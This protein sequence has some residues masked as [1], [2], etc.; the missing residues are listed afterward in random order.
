MP[1]R[2]INWN[3]DADGD[4]GTAANWDL[5]RLPDNRDNAV[6]DTADPHTV[7]YSAGTTRV[8]TITVG[9]D[10]FVVSGGLFISSFGANFGGLLSV[11][12]G[13]MSFDGAASSNIVS[14]FSQTGG[15]VY[16]SYTVTGAADFSGHVKQTGASTTTVL[17]GNSTF[18]AR[19]AL[20][21]DHRIINQGAITITGGTIFASD[22]TSVEQVTN[23][24]GG[25]IDIQGVFEIPDHGSGFG[26][27]ALVNAGTLNITA[28]GE[29]LLDCFFTDTGTVN[30][31]SGSLVL[32]G[33]AHDSST[34]AGTVSGAGSLVFGGGA[35][36]LDA[37]T[38]LTVSSWT[39]RQ[40]A[41]GQ[42]VTTAVNGIVS[43]GGLFSQGGHTTVTI[44]AGD[45]LRFTG[46][47]GFTGGFDAATIAGAG[48]LTFAGGTQ[49]VNANVALEV[50]NWVIS[51]DAATTLNESLTY[52]GAFTLAAATTLSINGGKLA[53]TGAASLAGRVNGS[54]VLKLSNAAK[55]VAGRSVIAVRV[56]DVGSIEAARGTLAFT[57]AISGGGAMTVDAGATLEADSTVASS[58]SMTFNGGGGTLALGRHAQFAAT[59][60]GVGAGDTI[61]LLGAQATGATLQGGDRLV[62]TNGATTLA[63]LQLAGDYSAA[64]F[65]V[66]SDGKGG[67]NVT[68]TG[69]PRAAPFIAAMAG[70]GADPH[71]P[72]PAWIASHADAWRPMLSAARSVHF[73]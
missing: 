2:T 15:T 56:A 46:S 61:D 19:L 13:Q 38:I 65:N 67:T 20:A 72:G 42:A 7:T 47:A 31:S 17:Q 6:I 63:T 73:A 43:Y 8:K 33:N 36:A 32:G 48:T 29:T 55:A 64:T 59:I 69:A 49:A 21:F 66:A 23:E 51:N 70:L 57:G 68:V 3:V 5:G 52:A 62:I 53:L 54:G 50:A 71:G 44:G 40:G 11:T 37:G 14:A 39:M 35:Y 27:V 24:A 28:G 16:G 30:I 60:N 41:D 45:K 18:D 58:L 1:R 4:W 25:T 22:N 12:G 34:F 10:A 9:N 26:G